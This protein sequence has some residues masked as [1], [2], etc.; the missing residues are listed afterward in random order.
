MFFNVRCATIRDLCGP[1][2]YLLC[3]LWNQREVFWAQNRRSTF[4][5]C[6]CRSPLQ[7]EGVVFRWTRARWPMINDIDFIL[8]K[9]VRPCCWRLKSFRSARRTVEPE[10]PAQSVSLQGPQGLYYQPD[11]ALLRANSELPE[12]EASKQ[13][14][15]PDFFLHV[16]WSRLVFVGGKP[17]VTL[18]VKNQFPPRHQSQGSKHQYWTGLIN[19]HCPL[20]GVASSALL[21]VFLVFF[22]NGGFSIYERLKFRLPT[23]YYPLW[24]SNRTKHLDWILQNLSRE[25]RS[26][27]R[28][29]LKPPVEWIKNHLGLLDNMCQIYSANGQFVLAECTK[30]IQEYVYVDLLFDK[31][32]VTTT[33]H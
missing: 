11:N 10:P 13:R 26:H 8:S 30:T 9:M 12:K 3:P 17:L 32:Q 20:R 24:D 28:N 22:E 15:G 27:G 31:T 21:G 18:W 33:C 6:R 1:G 16:Y 29:S 2:L 4:V 19:H 14:S 25:H 23:I 7:P 5:G